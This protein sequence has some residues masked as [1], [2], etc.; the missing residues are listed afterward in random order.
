MNAQAEMSPAQET[1][2]SM[3]QYIRAQ[4]EVVE[5]VFNASLDQI[6][7]ENVV[8]VHQ[9]VDFTCTTIAA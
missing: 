1:E 8:P 4:D 7:F 3:E 6:Q 5:N 9:E 2:T